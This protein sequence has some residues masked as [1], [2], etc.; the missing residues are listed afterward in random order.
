MDIIM[1]EQEIMK[2]LIESM[3][4]IW[5]QHVEN[6]HVGPTFQPPTNN[7]LEAD[8]H[9]P[10]G[11]LPRD[12]FRHPNV[13]TFGGYNWEKDYYEEE[14]QDDDDYYYYDLCSEEE[15]GRVIWTSVGSP[16]TISPPRLE[17]SMELS[18]FVA[19]KGDLALRA[20]MLSDY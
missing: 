16:S 17:A 2:E 8:F 14:E 19:K 12:Q 4:Q 20:Q 18:S 9:R 6:N 5:I 10:W 15:Y 1:E 3:N 11:P 7:R 13:F